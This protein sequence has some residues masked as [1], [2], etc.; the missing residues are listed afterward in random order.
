[1]A[2][3]ANYCTFNYVAQTVF[4][5][6]YTFCMNVHDWSYMT[7]YT[8]QTLGKSGQGTNYATQTGNR[9]N[10]ISIKPT[11]YIPSTC[12]SKGNCLCWNKGVIHA[13]SITKRFLWDFFRN[14][15]KSKRVP[16][17][18]TQYTEIIFF[19]WHCIWQIFLSAFAY[20]S[21]PYSEALAMWM[22]VSYILYTTSSHEHTGNVIA[23]AH[24][25]EVN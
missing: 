6:I 11:C 8:N 18:R 10:K 13:S 3:I 4:W 17:L 22:A 23:F 15:T 2:N 21:R 19:T 12:C 16:C 20:M 25:E 9:H 7:C 14:P 24:F 1:M 5:Q